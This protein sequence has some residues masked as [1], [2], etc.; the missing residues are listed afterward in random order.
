MSKKGEI[1]QSEDG[2][3]PARPAEAR[4]PPLLAVTLVRRATNADSSIG[5]EEL[6]NRIYRGVLMKDKKQ[7]YYKQKFWVD[8]DL[9]KNCF[10][11]LAKKLSIIWGK[12]KRY[13]GWI[14]EAEECFK[15]KVWV[16]AAKLLQV[17]RLEFRGTF[18][19]IVLSPKTTYE[20]AFKV[21]MANSDS[22]W[23]DPVKLNLTL[24]DGTS[25]GRI[26]TLEGKPTETWIDI[27]VGTFVTTPT[28]VGK[29]C[30]SFDG[31]YPYWRSGLIIKGVVLR[32]K[33]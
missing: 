33:D 3:A 10:L 7:D 25:Q 1:E 30:F 28:N 9:G 4:K 12:D 8:K 15:G 31:T 2:S 18:K 32:P 21:K 23:H 13:W 20:V 17:C 6:C 11:L 16:P 29:I 19:T 24:P 22:S 26:E 14:D 27:L 5:V